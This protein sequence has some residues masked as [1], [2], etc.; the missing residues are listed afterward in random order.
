[1]APGHPGYVRTPQQDAPTF[2]TRAEA[3]ERLRI[4]PALLD[5][6]I[7]SGELQAVRLH[8]RVVI[9]EEALRHLAKAS[10]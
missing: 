9:P 5:R 8:R 4:G 2:L 7:R 6:M 3:A 1:M 10:G